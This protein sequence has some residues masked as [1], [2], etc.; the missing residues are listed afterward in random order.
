MRGSSVERSDVELE[1]TVVKNQSEWLV[2]VRCISQQEANVFTA[3][4]AVSMLWVTF[5][6]VAPWK[7]QSMSTFVLEN[8]YT[9]KLSAYTSAKLD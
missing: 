8:S 1:Q 4:R 3:V 5:S 2:R 6:D 7:G 9:R